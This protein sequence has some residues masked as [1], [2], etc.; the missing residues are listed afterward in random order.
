MKGRLVKVDSLCTAVRDQVEKM[1]A[2][3]DSDI[4][5]LLNDSLDHKHALRQAGYMRIYCPA[6]LLPKVADYTLRCT[7]NEVRKA[8]LDVM[9]WHRLAYTSDVCLEV[10]HKIAADQSLPQDVRDEARRCALRI[11]N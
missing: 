6:Y 3:W 10:A 7:D 4:M 1:G 8:L 5:S 9:G 11:T 2:R